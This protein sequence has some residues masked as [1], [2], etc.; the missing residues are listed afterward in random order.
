MTWQVL[1]V[2][3]SPMQARVTIVNDDPAAT[4]TTEYHAADKLARQTLGAASLAGSGTGLT[5]RAIRVYAS[6]A[7]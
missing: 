6:Q 4:P 5:G 2:H 3:P 7:Y 1:K